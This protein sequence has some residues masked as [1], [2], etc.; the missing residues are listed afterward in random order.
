MTF[1]KLGATEKKISPPSEKAPG[2]CRPLDLTYTNDKE[3]SVIHWSQNYCSG[4]QN[5]NS[6]TP[7]SKNCGL[8]CQ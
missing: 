5:V 1:K 6:N 7:L 8:P 4:F 2:T 3:T